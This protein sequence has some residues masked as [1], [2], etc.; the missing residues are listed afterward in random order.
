M[1]PP[2]NVFQFNP[3]LGTVTY[4]KDMWPCHSH[5]LVLLTSLMGK[6]EFTWTPSC[7]K[8]FKEVKVVMTLEALY[9]YPSHNIPSMYIQIH[10]IISLVIL[11]FRMV[12]Q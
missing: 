8:A 11:S 9:A 12:N 7:Q 4:Y 3:F 5:M 2:T 6:A 1:S 10:W